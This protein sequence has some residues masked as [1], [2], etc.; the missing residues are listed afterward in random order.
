MKGK[1][2]SE[3]RKGKRRKGYF[4]FP[5]FP[6]IF[7]F[8]FRFFLSVFHDYVRSSKKIACQNGSDYFLYTESFSAILTGKRRREL[9]VKNPPRRRKFS[10]RRHRERGEEKKI[11]IGSGTQIS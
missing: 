6:L 9:V 4:L 1:G 3:E 11:K 5:I 8:P 10:P 2:E 7:P